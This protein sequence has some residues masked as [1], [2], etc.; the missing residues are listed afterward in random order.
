ML[1]INT[2]YCNLFMSTSFQ[3]FTSLS[4]SA[5][6]FAAAWRSYPNFSLCSFSLRSD[7]RE[8]RTGFLGAVF[9]IGTMGIYLAVVFLDARVDRL[10][11]LVPCSPS[12]S[13]SSRSKSVLSESGVNPGNGVDELDEIVA[14]PMAKGWSSRSESDSIS[15]YKNKR[16]IFM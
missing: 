6:L 8:N 5:M 7:A 12:S 11:G 15:S 16:V 14:A 10:V 1:V 2:Q 9:L 3:G 13:V 4:S